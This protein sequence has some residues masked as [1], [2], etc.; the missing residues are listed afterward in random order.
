M[1]ATGFGVLSLLLAV[2][3]VGILVLLFLPEDFHPVIRTVAMVFS[4][5][6]F[7]VS[8]VVYAAFQPETYHFQLV[9]RM[10]WIPALGIQYQL[11]IDGLSLWLVLL[12]TFMT[13]I[14]SWASFSIK[15][16]VRGYYICLFLLQMAL[17]GVFMS[18]DL[19]LIYVFFELSLVPIYFLIAVWGGA[20]KTYAANKF[21]I[22]TFAA[23][24]FML[25]GM[26]MLSQLHLEAIG[27]RSFDLLAIQGAVANGTLWAGA[28]QLQPLIFWAFMLAFM[29]K[30]PM[31]PFHT[32]L[33]DAYSNAPA[34]AMIMIAAL[35]VKMGSYGILRLLLPLFPDT[36]Q[37]YIPLL[38]GLAIVAIIYGAVVAA[39]QP[40]LKKLIGYSSVAHMG[41]VT[42]GIFSLTHTGMMGG[43]YQQLNHGIS[44][45]LLFL[46]VLFVAQRLKTTDFSHLGGLKKRMPLFSVIF[47]IAMLSGV[48]MPGT[49][50]FVGEFL[51]LMGA[52]EST[53]TNQFGLNIWFSVVAGTGVFLA[54]VYQL[55]MFQQTFYGKPKTVMISRLKDLK[56]G[57]VVLASTL[58][59]FI[60]WGG[61]YPST[62]LKPLEQ[63]VGATRMMSLNPAGQR[64]SWNDLT[65]ELDE[66]GNLVR[67]APR[68][69]NGDLAAFEVTEM[70]F[71]DRKHYPFPPEADAPPEFASAQ[72]GG[73]S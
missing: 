67:V 13:V 54:A 32:W 68:V 17:L 64:P 59:L 4:L 73:E 40:D 14:A 28:M 38:L 60:F 49:N 19:I 56:T 36:L 1:E 34:P 16:K 58:I 2:P 69:R 71:E 63:S 10:D 22:Y 62:F 57:E 15:E 33:P 61:L 29:V 70:V 37:R 24:I 47:L 9:E 25:V 72:P 50:G 30:T 3:L 46:M 45:G 20:N 21:L 55:Y 53:R 12:T 7:G 44:T 23:S 5:I 65:L 31:F 39:V 52:F 66:D 41:F 48:G 51:A 8:L 18:L 35:P 43:S 42:L 6:A 27:T 26:V 11:G